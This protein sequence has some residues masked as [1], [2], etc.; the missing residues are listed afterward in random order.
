M[1]SERQL[2][3][4]ATKSS[5]VSRFFLT[6]AK[7]LWKEA[8]GSRHK[9]VHVNIGIRGLFTTTA[10]LS[11]AERKLVTQPGNHGLGV[12]IPKYLF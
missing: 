1:P 2:I 12:H 9:M 6:L 8:R 10:L 4:D 3:S 11:T 5:P 7:E